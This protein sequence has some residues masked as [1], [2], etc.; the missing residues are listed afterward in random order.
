M[1]SILISM[2]LA[3]YALILVDFSLLF[4]DMSV[5][6]D[7][8]TST[9]A[10]YSAEGAI[11]GSFLL[12]S[13]ASSSKSNI[14]FALEGSNSANDSNDSFL[15]YNEESDSIYMERKMTSNESDQNTADA[16]NK[17]NRLVTDNAYKTING[18]LDDKVVY[19]LE[20][21][22]A[23]S[24]VL[25][26]VDMEQNFNDIVFSYN[27]TAES[28][29]LLFEIFAFPRESSDIDFLDFDSIKN[30]FSPSVRRVVINSRDASLNGRSFDTGGVP[31]VVHFE[32]SGADYKNQ[33]RVS[34]FQPYSTNYV[35]HFQ[36]LD[37]N[38]IH[39]K[40]AAAYNGVNVMIPALMQTID[41][42]G[43][44][45]T[46]LYQRVKMQ[47]QT[48]EGVMPGLNFVH[49]SNGPIHK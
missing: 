33:I 35:I 37:N 11:E 23:R 8:I 19:G 32:T 13:E 40:I 22:K 29:D 47:R 45:P 34:G 44:T 24:F 36:T 25:K 28:S 2:A 48:E 12:A 14:R 1:Y 42:I 9:Q 21:S 27:Q 18:Y 26:E 39:Y 20:A 43:A 3:V 4:Q 30:G 41:V 31:L 46:G 17:N 10:L 7:M 5:N 15:V 16:L 38:A 6:A 49:F